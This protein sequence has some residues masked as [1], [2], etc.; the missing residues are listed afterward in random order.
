MTHETTQAAVASAPM[1]V[2]RYGPHPNAR[3]MPL[4]EAVAEAARLDKLPGQRAAV[5]QLPTEKS[6]EA[7]RSGIGVNWSTA[8]HLDH[9][10]AHYVDACEAP[11]SDSPAKSLGRLC[12]TLALE[13]HLYEQQYAVW[14]GLDRRT[15]AGKAAWQAFTAELGSRSVVSASDVATA[16]GVADAFRSHPEIAPLLDGAWFELP[17]FWIEVVNGVSVRCK[18]L[19]DMYHPGTGTLI[20]L[21]TVEST[22]P[23]AFGRAAARYGWFGQGAWYADGAEACGLQVNRVLFA[24]IEKTGHHDAVVYESTASGGLYVGRMQK[25]GHL[26]T[27]AHCMTSEEWPGRSSRIEPLYVPEYML[28][29]ELDIQ[30]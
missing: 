30:F 12:H 22:H 27:L 15:K 23:R 4:S 10:A 13:P 11:S 1:H 14:S 20:D 18:G 17:L 8:K 5:F 9:S 26:A 3:R 2:A 24:A 6:F 7:Y 21:K 28:G 29:D 19:L 16:Q 25:R